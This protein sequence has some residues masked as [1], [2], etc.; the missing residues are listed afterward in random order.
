MLAV[1][2][3][4]LILCNVSSSTRKDPQWGVPGDD[5]G[6]KSAV[7]GRG[8]IKHHLFLPSSSSSSSF[9]TSL[10]LPQLIL[11]LNQSSG[12]TLIETPYS[13]TT[14]PT[15]TATSPPAPTA[16]ETTTALETTEMAPTATTTPTR[17]I[18]YALLY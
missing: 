15:D 18:G 6:G 12:S 8:Y 5:G 9:I 14:C 2:I 1:I 13:K 11:T 10:T 17:M 3:S 16:R 7:I 4:D